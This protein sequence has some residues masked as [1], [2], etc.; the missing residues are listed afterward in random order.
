[1]NEPR[2]PL[3]ELFAGWAPARTR[4]EHADA[5]EEEFCG[6]PACCHH[7]DSHDYEATGAVVPCTECPGGV[8]VR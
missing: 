6:Y 4:P 1:M 7:M 2:T 3:D 5:L 8:C